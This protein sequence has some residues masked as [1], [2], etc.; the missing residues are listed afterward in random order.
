MKQQGQECNCDVTQCVTGRSADQHALDEFHKTATTRAP[1]WLEGTP[2]ISNLCF[3]KNE[4]LGGAFYWSLG[5]Y[6]FHVFSPVDWTEIHPKVR[7][8]SHRI[9]FVRQAN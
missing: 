2:A 7:A 1:S 6:K 3:T 8:G 9:D 5:V 4:E